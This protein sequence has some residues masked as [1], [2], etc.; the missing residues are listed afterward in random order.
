M[1][2]NYLPFFFSSSRKSQY[3]ISILS[4]ATFECDVL[5]VIFKEFNHKKR[6]IFYYLRPCHLLPSGEQ[7]SGD[8]VVPQAS[9]RSK[10]SL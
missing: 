3:S 4:N 8:K 7:L 2:L 1:A 10:V 9:L 6:L 5:A